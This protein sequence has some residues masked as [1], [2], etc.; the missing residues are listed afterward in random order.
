MTVYLSLGTNL[1]NK[2]INLLKAIA[3]IAERIGIFSAISSVYETEPWG[4]ESD[5]SFLNMVVSVE[6][7][8][9]PLEIL[10][11]TQNIEKKIGRTEKSNGSYH[12]RLIDIDIILYDDL[13][14]QSDKLQLPHPL[15]HKRQFVLK[16]LNEIAP[17][18]IHPV[19]NKTISSLYQNLNL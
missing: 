15:F 2:N 16:P 9:D 14:F 11:E 8:L 1:G 19:F 12:D 17:E 10:K 18:L 4:F 3:L 5:N 13:V 6:T 7:T